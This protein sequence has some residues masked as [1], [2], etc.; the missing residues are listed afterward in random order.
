MHAPSRSVPIE[1][2]LAA[3]NEL[4]KQGRFRRFGLS[5]YLPSEVEEVIRVAKE[6]GFVVPSVFQGNYSVVARKLEQEMFPILRKHNIAFYAYSPIAGGFLTKT[7]SFIEAANSGRWDPNAPAGKIYSTLYNK[8]SFLELLSEW[9]VISTESGIPKAEL[10]YR[11]V[12]HNSALKQENG[13]AVVFGAMSPEQARQT[14]QAIKK[15]PLPET[16]AQKVDE[17]WNLIKDEAGLDNFNL[18]NA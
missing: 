3:I 10:A 7:R 6:K 11:W 2:T 13:D 12:A 17:L 18:N 15:G 1:E 4:Y 16:V 14:I 8:P 5:N 9:E